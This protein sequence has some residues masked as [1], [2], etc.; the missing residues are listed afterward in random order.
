MLMS[1]HTFTTFFIC[2]ELFKATLLSCLALFNITKLL[3]TV[4]YKLTPWERKTH[5]N[6]LDNVFKDAT[7]FKRIIRC[8]LTVRII[9]ADVGTL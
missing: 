9:G 7:V 4:R 3:A 5:M 8:G 1:A 6:V 2:I